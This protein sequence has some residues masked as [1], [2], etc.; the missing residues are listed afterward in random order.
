MDTSGNLTVVGKIRSLRVTAGSNSVDLHR[1][2][3]GANQ[4]RLLFVPLSEIRQLT[5]SIMSLQRISE[6]PMSLVQIS[7][8]SDGILSNVLINNHLCAKLTNRKIRHFDRSD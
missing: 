8:H 4:H 2:L 7:S 5:I 6:Q 3:L 1:K